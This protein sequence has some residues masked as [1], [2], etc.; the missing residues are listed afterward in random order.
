VTV[1]TVAV[2]LLAVFVAPVFVRS[3][4]IRALQR[5]AAR[6]G[7]TLQVNA[8]DLHFGVWR[9]SLEIEALGVKGRGLEGRLAFSVTLDS[10][11]DLLRGGPGRDDVVVVRLGPGSLRFG[12]PATVERG[13]AG[14]AQEAVEPSGGLPRVSLGLEA[15]DVETPLGRLSAVRGALQPPEDGSRELRGWLGAGGGAASWRADVVVTGAEVRLAP[16]AGGAWVFD[17]PGVG[18]VEVQTTGLVLAPRARSAVLTAVRVRAEG[19]LASARQIEATLSSGEV[20]VVVSDLEFVR[21]GERLPLTVARLEARLP[22]ELGDS[23]WVIH[24]LDGALDWDALVPFV[25]ARL[26]EAGGG[27]PGAGATARALPLGIRLPPALEIER[28]RIDL[29]GAGLALDDVKL[30]LGPA[31]VEFSASLLGD[32]RAEGSIDGRWSRPDGE[33]PTVSLEYRGCLPP[34]PW[35][36]VL[37]S[38]G[39]TISPGCRDTLEIAAVLGDDE[40]AFSGRVAV[41]AWTVQQAQLATESM[42]DVGFDVEFEG[43]VRRDLDAASIRLTS[44]TSGPLRLSGALSAT[45]LNA[46]PVFDLTLDVPSQACDNLLRA[47]P[48]AMR[49]DLAGLWLG[50]TFRLALRY[51][52]DLARVFTMYDARLAGREEPYTSPLVLDGENLCEVT[53]PPRG[54]DVDALNR[55]DFVHS[56]ELDDGRVIKVGPGTPSFSPLGDLPATVVQGALAT[57]DLS[58][59]S[60][61]GVNPGLLKTALEMDLHAGRFKY[62][63]STITQ[64]LVKNLYLSRTKTIARKIEDILLA[65]YVETVVAKDRLLELYLNVIEYGDGIYGI[66]AASLVYFGKE[67]RELF[68]EEAAFL[69]TC[70]PA[71]PDCQRLLD[72]GALTPVWRVKV[73]YVLDRLYR[74]VKVIDEKEYR[75]ALAREIRFLGHGGGGAPAPAVGGDLLDLLP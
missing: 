54:I 52:V 44:F 51:T 46:V 71:P 33:P 29:A 30:A 12:P 16:S 61:R 22:L 9:P 67:P 26:G 49:P 6:Y 17:A 15:I 73:D 72:R 20:E 19:S 10:W 75:D 50:G 2:L 41:S 69:M 74:R 34:A 55:A 8:D 27:A 32:E 38:Q 47:L 65:L 25:R 5:A 68:P 66:R 36:A 62:G 58:F 43:S 64:Q 59:Y 11:T 39:L 57:E 24:R 1:A 18:A 63:G 13:D 40:V 31:H 53:T 35:R 7:L 14:E 70:K 56:V 28:G 48:E 60:H 45:R 23:G 42:A 3:G 37:A 4:V 21:A